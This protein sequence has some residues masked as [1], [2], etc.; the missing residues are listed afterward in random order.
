VVKS[1][2]LVMLHDSK[3]N[4]WEKL[5]F[6]LGRYVHSGPAVLRGRPYLHVHPSPHEREIQVINL[7]KAHVIASPDVE[8]LLGVSS[9]RDLN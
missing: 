9:F 1:G 8:M 3:K 2:A 5:F 7:E 6:A 4:E